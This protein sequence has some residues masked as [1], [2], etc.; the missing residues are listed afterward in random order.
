MPRVPVVAFLS[1]AALVV[2]GPALAP[3]SLVTPMDTETLVRLSTVVVRGEVESVLCGPGPEGALRTWVTLRVEEHL[4][5]ATGRERVT[6]R[7]LGGAWHNR[8]SLVYGMPSFE[9]GE[10]VVV[11]ATRTRDGS[12]TLVGMSQGKYRIEGEPGREEAVRGREEPRARRGARSEPPTGRRPLAP[13][14]ERIRELSRLYPAVESGDVPADAAPASATPAFTL[15]NPIVPLRWFEPDAGTPILLEFNPTGAPV[16]ASDARAGFD[17]GRGHWT[18]VTGSSVVVGDGGDTTLACRV[19]SDGSVISH[20]DP[21]G[22]LPPFDPTTCSGVLAVTGVSGFTLETKPLNG[23]TFLRLTEADIVMNAD[24]ECFFGG[25]DGPANY[26]EVLTHEMGHVIGLGHSCG[27]SYSPACVPGTEADDAL[28]RAFA[29]GGGRGGTL[30][31]GDIDGARFLY[32][33][34]GFVDAIL[35]QDAFAAGD[36]QLLSLDLNGTASADLYLVEVLP[37]G[38]FVSLAPGLP[39]NTLAP[40]ARSV[41]LRFAV[42]VPIVDYTFTG[43]EPAGSYLWVAL[44]VRAGTDPQQ[45]TNLLWYDVAPFTVGP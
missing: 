13:F 34:A 4:K 17:R 16:S 5:G 22:Q 29:H 19:F 23:L 42:D 18:D 28:M 9:V 25:P 37:G 39:V 8:V 20:G 35:N 1:A 26:E 32:P 43:A 30:G 38:T 31:T 36:R 12:L 44:L 15:L 7:L 14:L 2:L 40:L 6:L 33:T 24:T 27:D 21:C 3:A 10:R 11:F 45:P 41:P